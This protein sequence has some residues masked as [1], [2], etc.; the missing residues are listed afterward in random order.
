MRAVV[1]SWP[2]ARG[3]SACFKALSHPRFERF[4][5]MC[6][7]P[8]R[9]YLTFDLPGLERCAPF[10]TVSPRVYVRVAAG[11]R[12]DVRCQCLLFGVAHNRAQQ[13][14]SMYDIAWRR[15]AD[16]CPQNDGGGPPRPRASV[17]AR[18]P[19]IVDPSSRRGGARAREDGTSGSGLSG[20]ACA[21]AV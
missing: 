16:T 20:C 2:V 7:A 6:T 3:G 13:T 18:Q 17:Q 10:F 8:R 1:V 4:N 19:S 12:E 14:R 15:R 5:V 9:L 11:V 21:W